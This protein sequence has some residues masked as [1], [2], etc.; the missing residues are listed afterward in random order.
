MGIDMD[1]PPAVSSTM[2]DPLATS[3]D[4]LQALFDALQEVVVHLGPAVRHEQEP[5][6][7]EF[8]SHS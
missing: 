3:E 7:S 2:A 5:T 6:S 1:C 8:M 4:M